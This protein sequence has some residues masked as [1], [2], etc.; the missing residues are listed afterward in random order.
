MSHFLCG[1]G[2]KRLW[3]MLL[4]GNTKGHFLSPEEPA[5][6]I[7]ISG[8]LSVKLT[9]LFKIKA[10]THRCQLNFLG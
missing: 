8:N 6:Q 3:C 4:L 2:G 1:A 5:A 9:M 7:D 10:T